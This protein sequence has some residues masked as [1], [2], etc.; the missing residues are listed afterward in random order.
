MQKQKHS[1]EWRVTPSPYEVYL[2]NYPL[3]HPEQNHNYS[4]DP[5]SPHHEWPRRWTMLNENWEDKLN[6]HSGP[7]YGLWCFFVKPRTLSWIIYYF[8]GCCFWN[9]L[10]KRKLATEAMRLFSP[11]IRKNIYGQTQIRVN[12]PTTKENLNILHK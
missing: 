5:D 11:L 2:T 4:I 7:A 12:Q 8:P 9:A 6:R 3:P 1:S 10:K